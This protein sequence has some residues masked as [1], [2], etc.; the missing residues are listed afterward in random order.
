MTKYGLRT[1]NLNCQTNEIGNF[2]IANFHEDLLFILTFCRLL[3][4]LK[5]DKINY[6]KII[7][8]LLPFLTYTFLSKYLDFNIRF[9]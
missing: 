4:F 8:I 1:Y 9:Y 5:F 3:F 2:K 7:K 6:D